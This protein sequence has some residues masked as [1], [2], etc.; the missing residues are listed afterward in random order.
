MSFSPPPLREANSDPQS[1]LAGF[2]GHFATGG[3]EEEGKGKKKEKE[4][5]TGGMGDKHRR[6]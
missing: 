5:W 1:S 2:E 3:G 6:K 4:K